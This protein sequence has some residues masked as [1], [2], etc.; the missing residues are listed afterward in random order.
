LHT[1]GLDPAIRR[2]LRSAFYESGH[3][4]YVEGAA[5][6]KF[7]ADFEAWLTYALN[8]PLVPNAQRPSQ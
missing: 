6:V 5:R 7:K 8:A 4:L 2:N 1:M 3:M